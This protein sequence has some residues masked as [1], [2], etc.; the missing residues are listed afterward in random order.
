M[1]RALVVN[2]R[3]IICRVC[4]WMQRGGA[5][6]AA[7]CCARAIQTASSPDLI[8]VGLRAR[9]SPAATGW[10]M[11]DWLLALW[12]GV[13]GAGAGASASAPRGKHTA[14]TLQHP[15]AMRNAR[16]GV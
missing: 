2:W 11:L 10:G 3:L 7:V 12:G 9:W 6:H 13:G 14:Y 16:T 15:G 4:V 1:P 5:M 8:Q